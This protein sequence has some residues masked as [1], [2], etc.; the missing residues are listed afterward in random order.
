MERTNSVYFRIVG[1]CCDGDIHLD[2]SYVK[3]IF[4]SEYFLTVLLADGCHLCLSFEV[5]DPL[6][7]IFMHDS[8]I[9]GIYNEVTEYWFRIC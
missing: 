2:S 7:N 4:A 6:E 5:R 9:T 1:F 8:Y 3:Y